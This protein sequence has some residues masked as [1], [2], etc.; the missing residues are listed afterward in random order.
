MYRIRL[1]YTYILKRDD[2][3]EEVY[4]QLAHIVLLGLLNPFVVQQA[5]IKISLAS[6]LVYHVLLDIFAIKVHRIIHPGLVIVL[7]DT[8]V[9]TALCLRHNIHVQSGLTTILRSAIV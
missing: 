3:Q 2:Y 1:L 6:Q 7:L 9:L 5:N 8:I 4:A